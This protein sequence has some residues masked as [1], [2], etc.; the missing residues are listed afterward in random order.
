MRAQTIPDENIP[1]DFPDYGHL[2]H[3]QERFRTWP[4]CQVSVMVGAGFSLNSRPRSGI[5][6]RFP[7]WHELSWAMFN[8]IYPLLSNATYDQTQRRIDEFNRSNALRIASKYVAK[9]SREQLDSF[10]LKQIPDNDHEPGDLHKLL[11]E[12]P[13]K[14]VFTTN[15]DTLLERPGASE[16]QYKTVKTTR[17]LAKEQSPRIIKLHGSFYSESRP[18]ITE[19]DYRTYED[20]FEPFIISVKNSLV[21]NVFVLVGFS[22]DDPNFLDWNGWIRDVIGDKRNPIYLVGPL[23]LDD[24]DRSLYKD[25]GVT[26]IDLSPVFEGQAPADGIHAAALDWFF[27]NLHQMNPQRPERWPTRSFGKQGLRSVIQEVEPET[28]ESLVGSQNTFDEGTAIKII[29]RWRFERGQYPGWLIP[30]AELRASLWRTTM[31][32]IPNLIEAAQNWSCADQVLL[33]REIIWRVEA[34][35]IPLDTTLIEP[36]ENAIDELLPS[37]NNNN[38][39]LQPTDKAA[40]LLSVP[41]AE[42]Q[43]SWLEVALALLR[44]SRESFDG[45]RWDRLKNK[46]SQVVYRYPLHND[47]FCYEQALW[48]LWKFQNAQARSLL[49]SWSP[50]QN[51]PL[52]MMWK[53]GILVELDDQE[54]ARTLLRA[55]LQETRRQT[56]QPLNQN[57]RQLSLEGWCTYLLMPIE[58]TL[59]LYNQ[60]NNSQGQND[61][62]DPNDLREKFLN[63]WDELKGWDCDP[64]THIDYFGKTLSA[65]PPASKETPGIVPV[66][67]P[68]RY[69]VERPLFEGPNTKWLPAFSFVRMLETVGIPLQYLGDTLKD[70]AEW[71]NPFVNFL[72]PMLLVRAGNSR[73]LRKCNFMSRTQIASMNPHLV[74]NL[75]NWAMDALNNEPFFA[76]NPPFMHSTQESLLET[77]I[78]FLSRLAFKLETPGLQNAFRAALKYHNLEEVKTHISLNKSCAFWFD[79]LFNA[80]GD[81]QLLEWMPDLIRFPLTKEN[82][83]KNSRHPAIT[84]PDPMMNFDYDRVRTTQNTDS[85]LGTEIHEATDWLLQNTKTIS[86]E[87]RQRALM[88]LTQ[89]FHTNLMSIEQKEHFGDL[90]WKKTTENDLPDLPNLALFSL[91]HLPSPPEV[92]TNSRLKQ[93][94]LG[95]KPRKSVEIKQESIS[96]S[97]PGEREDLMIREVSSAS[98][99]IIRLTSEPQGEIEWERTEANQLWK[100][101]YEWWEN[102]RHVI[103]QTNQNPSFAAGFDGYARL[104]LERISMFLARV[105]LPQMETATEEEWNTILS[106]LSGTRQDK[107]FLTPALPYILLKRPDEYEMVVSTVRD[108]LSSDDEGAVEAAA[109][110]V[111]HWAYLSN[112]TNNIHVPSEAINDLIARVIFRRPEGVQTC[113]AQLVNIIA[114]K[115]NLFIPSQIHFVVSSLT[116]WHLATC[117]PIPETSRDGFPEHER[118]RLRSLLGQLASALS[119]WL[120][121]NLSDQP[122]PIEISTLRELCNSDPLPE[123]RRSFD[124]S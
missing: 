17:D 42:I 74:R 56:H 65:D 49:A 27:K 21:E 123:V 115:P 109:K 30:N 103:Q 78:E 12:L 104:T 101:V 34:S 9:F 82:D 87:A 6:S 51:S 96:V 19:E 28:V 23:S 81:Q 48:L 7:T 39:R 33:Y 62:I 113:L 95:L 3:L 71:L 10:L 122:E 94:L 25:W 97:L 45:T 18:I 105:V 99:P 85:N 76:A 29:E 20:H 5:S 79:R 40:R 77:L 59:A 66:F 32:R 114:K 22:G 14:D 44:D 90:L 35:L 117:I 24:T 46:I 98:K 31:L 107:V 8:E 69:V 121:D 80:A 102:D 38:F 41:D 13:W 63:R 36:L 11:L 4:R 61:D 64:W 86:G 89:V 108:D 54:N 26:P 75:N 57:I 67:D 120:Q 43:E 112:E 70:A 110:A 53:A 111:S 1:R 100:D 15:Y 116:P 106:F 88:R 119:G 52:A 37:L 118:P 73:A 2:A 68:D 16:K 72:S 83:S 50:S 47:R 60:I 55:A 91:L 58:S 84:W 92:D 124:H 93:H